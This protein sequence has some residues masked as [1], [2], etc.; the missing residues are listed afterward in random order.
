[1]SGAFP[2]LGWWF[3]ACQLAAPLTPGWGGPHPALG[4]FVSPECRTACPSHLLSTLSDSYSEGTTARV[5]RVILSA[6][7][8]VSGHC[9][10][11]V[12]LPLSH[13]SFL[14]S[15]TSSPVQPPSL[16]RFCVFHI[17]IR[18]ASL[19]ATLPSSPCVLLF[20]LRLQVKLKRA[21]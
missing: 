18:S 8:T 2:G 11:V 5:T 1:M 12:F 16:L 14:L 21:Y 7:R 3:L 4:S 20:S 15:F 9:Y 19:R 13:Q 6:S 17:L 10:D